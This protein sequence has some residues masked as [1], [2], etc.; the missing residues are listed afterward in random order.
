MTTVLRRREL[1]REAAALILRHTTNG[2]AT[3]ADSAALRPSMGPEDFANGQVMNSNGIVRWLT[4][5]IG[6][7]LTSVCAWVPRHVADPGVTVNRVRWALG[8]R[9]LAI[10]GL[11]IRFICYAAR[12]CDSRSPEDRSADTSTSRS[13]HRMVA[14][15]CAGLPAKG[16]I[17]VKSESR[18]RSGWFRCPQPAAS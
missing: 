11:T 5:V 9:P 3:A 4:V 12:S 16:S 15:L 10:S 18:I 13:I 6:T 1:R 2:R 8:P 7:S 17:L 14:V